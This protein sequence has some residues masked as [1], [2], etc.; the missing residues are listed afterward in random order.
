MVVDRICSRALPRARGKAAST[1][2]KWEGLGPQASPYPVPLA[3]SINRQVWPLPPL[4]RWPIAKIM[5]DCNVCKQ[6][7]DYTIAA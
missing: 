3:E 5:F 7:N 1:N 6:S 4:S 2:P